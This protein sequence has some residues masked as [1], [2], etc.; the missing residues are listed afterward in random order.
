MIKVV[1]DVVAPGVVT[2]VDLLTL[3]YKPTWNEGLCYGLT[4][5]GYIVG[6]LNLVKGGMGDF[7]TNLGVSSLPLT[8]RHIRD[9]V[10]G[11]AAARPVGASHYAF[12]SSPSPIR[13]TVV[14]EYEG[15]RL[16]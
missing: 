15:V 1:P 7:V 4:A 8:A 14:P 13:Q 6:G 11:G 3:E 5:L 9:R 16:S 10:K 12:R 2:A